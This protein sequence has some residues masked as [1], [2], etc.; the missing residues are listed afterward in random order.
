MLIKSGGVH[1]YRGILLDIFHTVFTDSPPSLFL[2]G[3]DGLQGKISFRQDSGAQSVG[4]S[5][6]T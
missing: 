2:M 4:A 6:H 5:T 1:L 3:K